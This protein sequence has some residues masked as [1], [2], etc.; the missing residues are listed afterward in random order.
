MPL[1]L[2]LHLL[3]SYLVKILYDQLFFKSTFVEDPFE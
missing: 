2:I 1:V 3:L